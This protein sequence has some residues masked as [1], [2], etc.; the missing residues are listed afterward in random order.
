MSEWV[1][2]TTDPE[3]LDIVKHCHIEFSQDPCLFSIHGQRN[4]DS[5]QQAIINEEVDKLLGLGVV[6]PSRHEQGECLSPIFVTPKRDGSYIL[7]FNFKNCD[8]AVLYRHFKMDTLNSVI[9]LISPGA[10]FASLDLK[11]AYYTIPVALEQRTFLKFLW[12]GN[13]YEFNALPMGLSSSPRIF[14]KVMKPPL[15]YLR[16][17]ECTVS[18][19]IDDFFIQGND[20]RECYSSLEEAVLLFL[21]L[22]FHVHPEKSVLLPSQSLTFLGFNLNS[23]SMTVTLT[24]EKR[25]QLESLCTEA[26]NGENLSIRF[27]AKV[28]GKVVSA[29]PGVEFGRLHYCN[30]ERDKIYALSAN[31][32]DYDAL[33][34]L[35]PAA[36]EELNW[37]CDNVRHVCLVKSNMP[38]IPIVFRLM[39]VTAAGVSLALL[40]NPSSLMGFGPRNKDPFISM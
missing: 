34:Q 24:R 35:F 23:V 17:K 31:Q 1:K 3:I 9:S 19:Y 14:T 11:H 7:I 38:L 25:D 4:F 37:W 27:V 33:M 20:S 6:S 22:G 5:G 12:L 26:M 18:G 39:L 8:Q 2:L 30:L 10:Y 15:A 36:K 29:L 28:I 40:T 16:Q 13:L 21:Q 32:G